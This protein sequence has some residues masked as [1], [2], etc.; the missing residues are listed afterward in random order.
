MKKLKNPSRVG[1]GI[2]LGISLDLPE[3]HGAGIFPKFITES[4]ERLV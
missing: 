1:S 3:F 4:F 2:K